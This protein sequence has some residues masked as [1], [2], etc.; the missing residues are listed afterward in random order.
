MT[1]AAVNQTIIAAQRVAYYREVLSFEEA[2][3][4][5]NKKENLPK[6]IGNDGSRKS[7]QC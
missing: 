3:F 4:D 5:V 7:Y 1:Q 6:K 2:G